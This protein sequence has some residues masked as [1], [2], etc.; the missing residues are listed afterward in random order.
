MYK[1][2]KGKDIVNFHHPPKRF[3]HKQSSRRN[4]C[5]IRRQNKINSRIRHYFLTNRVSIDWNCLNQEIIDIPY[6][7]SNNTCIK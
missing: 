2:S 4:N 6:I 7:T 3:D 5:R 1:T